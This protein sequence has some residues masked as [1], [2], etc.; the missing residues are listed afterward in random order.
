MMTKLPFHSTPPLWDKLKPLARQMRH[1]PTA[2]EITCGSIYA[3]GLWVGQNFG[4]S[5][6]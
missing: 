2:A 6:P 4:D 3:T 1:A 5:T